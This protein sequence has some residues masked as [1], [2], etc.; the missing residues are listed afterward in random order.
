MVVRRGRLRTL[1]PWLLVAVGATQ[2]A[3][4]AWIHAKAALAQALL[5]L[6]WDATREG[7]QPVRPWPWADTWPVARL[8]LPRLGASMVVLAG[9]SGRTLAFGPGHTLGSAEPGT[10]GTTL[11]SGHRD[12][13]FS[14]LRELIPGDAIEIERRDGGVIRYLVASLDVVDARDSTIRAVY[15]PFALVLVTCWPFDAI[16]PGGPL[17]FVV[18]AYADADVREPTRVA[19]VG[20]VPGVGALE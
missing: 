1:V 8:S 4:G 16:T 7:G 12:T 13:H 6:A 5:E 2:V 10:A 9:D 20:G 3:G 17:R 15:E 14:V 19:S 11:V 18:T